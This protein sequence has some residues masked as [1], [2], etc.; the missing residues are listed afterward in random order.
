MWLR[1]EL[2]KD[3]AVYAGFR[4]CEDPMQQVCDS[5][6]K[7]MSDVVPRQ[8]NLES[9]RYSFIGYYRSKYMG[10]T[11]DHSVLIVSDCTGSLGSQ[12]YTFDGTC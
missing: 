2:N 12:P 6:C 7:A 3:L 8:G 5:C 1:K 10:M 9:S 4:E 11:A